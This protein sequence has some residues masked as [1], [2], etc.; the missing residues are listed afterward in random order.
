M[1]SIGLFM[2]SIVHHLHQGAC[3]L[4]KLP[5]LP[6]GPNSSSILMPLLKVEGNCGSFHR[7]SL[8]KLSPSLKEEER[9]GHME[10]H[11]AELCR[12]HENVR[13]DDMLLVNPS[14]CWSAVG[15]REW[16]A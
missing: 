12:Q 10:L 2:S 4:E 9:R 7:F 5:P 16:A 13:L 11:P 8:T 1:D 14:L 3:L 15:I 6:P